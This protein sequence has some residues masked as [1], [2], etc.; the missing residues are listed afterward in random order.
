MA[1]L[2]AIGNFFSW[3]FSVF[4]KNPTASLLVLAAIFLMLYINSCKNNIQLKKDLTTAADVLKR[5]QER[6]SNNLKALTDTVK[7]LREDSIYTK[8][9]LA[10]K[11]SEIADLDKELADAA[12]RVKT[13]TVT[14]EVPKLVYITTISSN[15]STSDVETKVDKQGDSISIGI[16][17]QTP[18]FTLRTQ[19]WFSVLPDTVKKRLTIQLLDKYGVNKPSHLDYNLN[20]KLQIVQTELPDGSKRIYINPVDLQGNAIDPALLG[21]TNVKGVD[22]I[23]VPSTPPI[24][25]TKQK[26]RIVMGLGPQAGMTYMDGKLRP[27]VGVGLTIGLNLLK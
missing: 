19:T 13:I 5:E 18:L 1:I 16:G 17:T 4:K 2:S 26:P 22:F 14:K 23:D 24:T 21:I 6:T 11:Q 20:F 10:A 12:Q 15:I 8:R 9:I 27:Y 25:P 7:Y 3:I